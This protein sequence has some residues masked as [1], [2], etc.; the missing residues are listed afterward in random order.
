MTC[1]HCRGKMVRGH[2]PFQVDREDYHLVLDHVPAWVCGQCGEAYFE[3]SEVDLIQ[4]AINALDER[5][6]RLAASA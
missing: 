1:L 5:T 4:D 2:A 3:P 6:R